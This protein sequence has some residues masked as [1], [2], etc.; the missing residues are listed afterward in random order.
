V[1][2]VIPVHKTTFSNISY[3]RPF[4]LMKKDQKIKAVVQKA[5]IYSAPLKNSKLAAL[6]QW[7][8]S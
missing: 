2:T 6:K 4:S 8:F 7:N 5:K 1:S 3:F